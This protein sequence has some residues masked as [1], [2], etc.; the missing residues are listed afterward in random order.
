MGRAWDTVILFPPKPWI[1]QISF[2][3][4]RKVHKDAES[5]PLEAQKARS[6][7]ETYT[8]LVPMWSNAQTQ[9]S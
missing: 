2:C 4:S 5:V 9:T 8:S 3:F 7:E 1:D 6:F